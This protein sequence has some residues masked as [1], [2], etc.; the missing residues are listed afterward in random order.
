MEV[1]RS[2]SELEGEDN[3]LLEP[4][5]A[6]P[7][8]GVSNG[9]SSS[10]EEE[11]DGQSLNDEDD[12]ERDRILATM[13]GEGEEVVA[14]QP[15]RIYVLW[16]RTLL[17]FLFL[18]VPLTVGLG[19]TLALEDDHGC[20]SSLRV[21]A[22]V[23]LG[24]QT[25]MIIFNLLTYWKLRRLQNAGYH[26]DSPSPTVLYVLYLIDQLLNLIWFAWFIM[27]LNWIFQAHTTS[28]CHHTTYL[29][30]M[31][32]AII[33]VQM[34]IMSA[35]FCFCCCSCLVLLLRYCLYSYI[36]NQK[37]PKG[38]SKDVINSLPSKKFNA[39]DPDFVD[40]DEPCCGICLGNY[41][42]GED[43]RML[44]CKHYFH[45]ECVDVWLAKNKTCP[46][47]KRNVDE[48]PV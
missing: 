38:A 33:I 22:D 31:C 37:A 25:A 4:A 29:F 20:Q 5:Q 16:G 28:H 40:S 12:E 27:G 14:N 39:Q 6:D 47:C 17:F 42:E 19:L 32:M 36:R 8:S 34:L 13:N 15:T 11:R 23:Q 35:L 2:P 21:W 3:S 44:L 45:C 7:E 48:P 43:I 9:E 10:N 46:F 18:L 24:L 41:E 26:E 30:K 1:E